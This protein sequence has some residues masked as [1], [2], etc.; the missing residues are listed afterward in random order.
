MM[1]RTAPVEPPC[2]AETALLIP[3]E[4][5][6]NARECGAKA[7]NLARMLRAGLPVPP[8][9]V[10]PASALDAC[11]AAGAMRAPLADL[12]QRLGSP[13]ADQ[14]AAAEARVGALFESMPLPAPIRAA[15]VRASRQLV[16]PLAVRS[17]AAGEDGALASYAGLLCST[18]EVEGMAAL[19]RALRRT[20][21]SRWSARVA[22]YARGR[23]QSPATLAVIIQ[24]Q[25]Q[26]QCAGVLFTRSPL[27]GCEDEMLCEYC[28]GTAEHLVSGSITPGRL[29]I[30]RA[31]PLAP[32]A[33][34]QACAADA[35]PAAS[36][37]SLASF[38]LSAERLFG[39]AQDIEWAI[40]RSRRVWL[41]QSRPIT[42]TVRAAAQS[43]VWS[44]ANVNENFPAPISPLL[45]SI[46][47]P[48]YTHYFRNLGR[49]FGLSERRLR[50]MADDLRLV[51]GVH[52][53]RMYYNLSAIH[54]ILRRSPC[55]DRL[56]AWF[57][58]FTGAEV[59]AAE[60]SAAASAPAERRGE[61]RDALELVRVAVKTAW[62][63]AFI[64]RRV[65]AFEARIDAF[66]AR[67]VPQRLNEKSLI[68]L[69]DDLRAFLDIRLNRWT[70]AAL[71]DAAAMVCYGLLKA[72]VERN[73]P[74]V[75]DRHLHNSLLKGITGLKSAE[76]VTALWG[77]ARAVREDAHLHAL[78]AHPDS[79]WIAAQLA[80]D[81]RFTGF[82]ARLQDY[83][84]RWGFR[85]SG[86]LMLTVPSFQERP[87]EL[88][89]IIR[90]Y[91]SRHEADPEA[92]LEAQRASRAAITA[93]AAARARRRR[94][95]RWLPW[96]N[97]AS[98]LDLLR[99]ATQAAIGLRERARYKQALAYSRVRR[100]ALAA[101]GKLVQ[102]GMLEA[103]DD[104]FFL[105]IGELDDLLSGAAMHPGETAALVRLRK[106]AHARFE[107]Q[108]PDDTLI[109]APG[110]YEAVRRG[111]SQSAAGASLRGTSVCGGIARGPARVLAEV[112]Q[113]RALCPGDILVTR[114][115]DP[116]WAPVFGAIAGLV[117]ERGGMLS[118]GAILAREYGI[119]TVVGIAGAVERIRTGMAVEVDG[120]CGDVR[121]LVSDQK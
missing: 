78:F 42:A 117:L 41:V 1:R 13:D 47:A 95:L 86:E 9:F 58:D 120:D 25:V 106:D 32:C 10:L 64:E 54:S 118:H 96:P 69:R 14:A 92:Q 66:A 4:R 46:A 38:A 70:N 98:V 87:Q 109:T 36:L 75:S 53:G 8:G 24:S 33:F 27:P 22:R 23:S 111:S 97:N 105:S 57:D 65:S 100:I 93:D 119:P 114:Q 45:Y 35:L 39:A 110:D 40:D 79:A 6:L 63:Y 81:P 82:N 77:L 21:A 30:A 43:I 71:A 83:L 52:G 5:A 56:V 3:L 99:R 7:V 48:G 20:W 50:R 116:G 94:F 16:A 55:G 37:A 51:I 59:P 19:E 11:I 89:D 15:L 49:A 91:A 44:N 102:R 12:E 73:F 101:G 104:V 103:A 18:L 85:C 31:H 84:E 108:R 115:T 121:I 113:S 74:A 34:E 88:L 80:N 107:Q 68:A 17:S 62:Q 67:T 28:Q 60:R 112:A 29:S 76:P 90:A 2:G 72:A 26:A 61:L